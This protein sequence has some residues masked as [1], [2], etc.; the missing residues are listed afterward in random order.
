MAASS[1]QNGI[2]LKFGMAGHSK[3]AQIKRKKEANDKQKSALFSKLSRAISL[4]VI[5]GGGSTDP[6]LNVRLRFALAR[7]RVA[8]MSRDTIDRSIEKAQMKEFL[9]MREVVYEIFAPGGV[10]LVV[11]ATTD[12]VNRTNADVRLA[13]D[14]NGGKVGN[15]GSVMHQFE[16]CARVL[17]APGLEVDEVLAL[18]QELGAHEVDMDNE[19]AITLYIPFDTMGR[20]GESALIEDVSLWY[21][22]LSPMPLPDSFLDEVQ[23]C[24]EKLEAIDEVESVFSNIE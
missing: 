8:R 14:R 22:P 16:K 17:C 10:L 13:A 19:S 21:R 23:S 24:V 12:N 2:F 6:A 3:W 1:Q 5:E 11:V 7:A 4:A 15:Q 9:Q 18:A 20:V